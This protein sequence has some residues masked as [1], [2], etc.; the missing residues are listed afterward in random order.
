M[1]HHSN[2]NTVRTT[3][4]HNEFLQVHTT[5]RTTLLQIQYAHPSAIAAHEPHNTLHHE[6]AVLT[7]SCQGCKLLL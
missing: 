4:Q 6:N 7:G 2:H 5:V 1:H 3:L